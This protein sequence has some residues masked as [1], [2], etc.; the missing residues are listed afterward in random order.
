MCR[1]FQQRRDLLV[2][3]PPRS[4]IA[5]EKLPHSWEANVE[6]FLGCAIYVLGGTGW[7]RVAGGAG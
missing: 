4:V 1:T 7:G 3:W 6:D 2:V 5:L